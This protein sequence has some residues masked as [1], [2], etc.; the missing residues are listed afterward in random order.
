MSATREWFTDIEIV[1]L[2]MIIVATIAW[3]GVEMR[4]PRSH[5]EAE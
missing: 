2:T 4:F 3:N 5:I 1:K